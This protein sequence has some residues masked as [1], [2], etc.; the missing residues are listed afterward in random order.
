MAGQCSPCNDWLSA[1]PWTAGRGGRCAP[2]GLGTGR[3]DF[4]SVKKTQCV[5]G[6]KHFLKAGEQLPEANPHVFAWS[7]NCPM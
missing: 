6:T 5:T 1:V 7:R 2:L 3:E 4:R